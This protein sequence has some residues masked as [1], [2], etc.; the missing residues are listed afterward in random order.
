MINTLLGIKTNQTQKFLENGRRIPVT[1]IAVADNTVLQV[2]TLEKDAYAAVQL[3]L[4]IKKRPRKS[5]A[6]HAK[7]L[8]LT[9]APKVIKEVRIAGN[10]AEE[11]LI[12]TGDAISVD[13]VLKP[14]DIVSVTGTSKG[15]GFAGVVK[16]H[17]FG[18]G[19]KTHGQ[20]DRHRAPGSIG[21]GTTPGR[22]YKGKRMAG[23]MGSEKVT[24]ANLTV[25][26]VDAENK[27][28]YVSGLV[29][30]VKK[31][32]LIVT[33]VGENKKYVQ[34]M[35]VK[36][37]ADAAA[38]EEAA[39]AEAEAA[40]A[41]AAEAKAQEESGVS[42]EP[43]AEE[44]A[45]AEAVNAEVAETKETTEAGDAADEPKTDTGEEKG[46]DAPKDTADEE[47]KEPEKEPEEKVTEKEEKS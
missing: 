42:V 31:G 25:V 9:D 46:P 44:A 41:A 40:K 28:V 3:G 22:V 33:R 23:R 4:G 15:K 37:R 34:L 18:G 39:K 17:G 1:E 32:L 11:E 8:G 14:G 21:Q 30:G 7:K 43:A 26:D 29:P 5:L 12:K 16:R 20:S 27:K 38:A 24:V 47:V 10:D 13:A 19:P 45:K 6:G 36:Q 2:K 35:E